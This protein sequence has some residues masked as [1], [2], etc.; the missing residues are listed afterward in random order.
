MTTATATAAEPSGSRWRW[1][2]VPAVLL[3]V[4]AAAGALILGRAGS[5][6][7]H[8]VVFLV[9]ASAVPSPDGGKGYDFA[10]ISGAVA[11]SALNAADDDA[12]SLRRFG[13]TCDASD[14]TAQLVP[15]ATENGRPIVDAARG[16]EPTGR[17]TLHSGI[18]AAVDDL[19]E[20]DA[21][22]N[23]I[24]VIT[25]H[26]ADA[27]TDNTT[28]FD[29]ELRE[30]LDSSGLRLDFRFVGHR[31]PTAEQRAL[32]KTATASDAPRPVF[33]DTAE[34]LTGALQEFVVPDSYEALPADVPTSGTGDVFHP[35]AWTTAKEVRLLEDPEAEPRTL[36]SL[37]SETN[38]GTVAWSEDRTRIA[39][40]EMSEAGTAESLIGY[41]PEGS[42][43]L[44]NLADDTVRT[45][46]CEQCDI[47]FAGDRLISAGPGGTGL[48]AY[49]ADGGAPAQWR[50]EGLPAMPSGELH[51]PA[52]V[53]SSY[54][55][56]EELVAYVRPLYDDTSAH[57]VYRLTADGAAQGVLPRRLAENFQAVD[58]DGA[59]MIV[60]DV[61][62]GRDA[63]GSC[64][65]MSQ[66]T[67]VLT[68]DS[69]EESVAVAPG[70]GWAPFDAW[71]T[72]DGSAHVSYLPYR[73]QRIATG[74]CDF[75][76]SEDPRV[77][78]LEEG[79]EQWVAVSD[80][81]RRVWDVGGGSQAVTV[82]GEGG[83]AT[84]TLTGEGAERT[85][86]GAVGELFP[87]S[88][89]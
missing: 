25:A 84:L 66:R 8:R 15:A 82:L 22:H 46:D 71:F 43:R 38:P 78:A 7:E 56:G 79:A 33:T 67:K 35:F 23:R 52:Y 14:N 41:V 3:A 27:C 44:M 83:T 68:P 51:G 11:A 2:A 70:A 76:R 81:K 74:S 13:G 29:K 73:T 42:I 60:S 5:G 28:E 59:R 63:A 18:L 47:A 85:L 4:V 88:A 55:Q 34:E 75:V 77:Y 57:S 65:P 58:H 21:A 31:V 64:E 30:R 6:A 19:A 80:A 20:S 61:V 39:W 86:D 9:D 49:P 37:D 36:A 45:W 10:D 24:I 32:T 1:W 12:L 53:L 89:P 54:R 16:L 48:W 50:V 40:T 17:A 69:G 26:G 72:A 62:V 87:S